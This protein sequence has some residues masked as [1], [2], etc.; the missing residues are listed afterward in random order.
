M[1]KQ[2]FLVLAILAA[3]VMASHGQRVTL[4]LE[5]LLHQSETATIRFLTTLAGGK[6][7]TAFP[8]GTFRSYSL[9]GPSFHIEYKIAKD[10][11]VAA[12]V[13]FQPGSGLY[14]TT[15]Q[16]LFATTQ[17]FGE[18]RLKQTQNGLLLYMLHTQERTITAV[19]YDFTLRSLRK[20]GY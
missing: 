17:A 3:F 11:C 15:V 14:T 8:D 19:C 20:Q 1:Q 9:E 10:T 18:N 13:R 12:L 7:P 5:P 2:L 4:F 16:Q 6:K